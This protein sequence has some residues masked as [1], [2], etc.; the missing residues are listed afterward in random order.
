[1]LGRVIVIGN[2]C[3]FAGYANDRARGMI[4]MGLNIG[5][6]LAKL[7]LDENWER[8]DRLL[9]GLNLIGRMAQGQ[10]VT[11][12]DEGGLALAESLPVDEGAAV[13][14][15]QIPLGE[16]LE[17]C[18]VGADVEKSAEALL[19]LFAKDPGDAGPAGDVEPGGIGL[20]SL[21]RKLKSLEAESASGVP[22]SWRTALFADQCQH[23]FGMIRISDDGAG[24]LRKDHIS[25][26]RLTVPDDAGEPFGKGARRDL[27]PPGL[28]RNDVQ[29]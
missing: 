6:V 13:G 11:R 28:S 7:R 19:R 14:M 17:Q 26:D 21:A 5:Y 27:T 16:I 3:A 20:E 1:M 2:R 8:L 10:V 25:I 4:G 12:E 29:D 15:K 9:F 22:L 23:G 24:G 18:R